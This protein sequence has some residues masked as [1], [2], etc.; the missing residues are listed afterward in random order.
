M[1]SPLRHSTVMLGSAALLLLAPACGDSSGSSG[2]SDAELAGIIEELFDEAFRIDGLEDGILGVVASADPGLTFDSLAAAV[3]DRVCADGGSNQPTTRSGSDEG[4][5]VFELA[6]TYTGCRGGDPDSSARVIDGETVW[7]G[8]GDEDLDTSNGTLTSSLQ[9]DWLADATAA[10]LDGDCTAT[11][12]WRSSPST[13]VEDL[14]VTI[15][16]GER[17]W[18]CTAE[19]GDCDER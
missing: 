1:S 12:S 2:P 9:I 11:G 10:A 7:T 3:S 15:S 13:G 5:G 18:A 16:C 8:I 4:D 6:H 14:D 17:A 19:G